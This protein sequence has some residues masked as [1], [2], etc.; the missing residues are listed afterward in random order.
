MGGL[1]VPP[2]GALLFLVFTAC[3][4]SPTSADGEQNGGSNGG[5]TRVILG[6]P[7]FSTNI[8]EIFLRRGC[9]NSSCH[10]TAK[11]AG[12]DLTEGNA[13]ANL[14]NV[15]ST[16]EPSQTRVIPG[17]TLNSYLVIKL[18]G[19]QSFGVQM[20]NGQAPLDSVDMANIKNWIAKGAKNN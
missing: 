2:V 3:A 16:N 18:E 8:Q 15:Q 11:Q 17:D 6:D 20:P 10:G 5:T 1:R 19:R 14:V 12:L 9:T 4:G 13:Y 7:S